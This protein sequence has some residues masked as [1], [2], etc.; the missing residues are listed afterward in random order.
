[1]KGITVLQFLFC[2]LSAIVYAGQEPMEK[3]EEL[4]QR[5]EMAC[6]KTL[7]TIFAQAQTS[8]GAKEDIITSEWLSRKEIKEIEH[9]MSDACIELSFDCNVKNVIPEKMQ[10]YLQIK[11]RNEVDKIF[12]NENV[13]IDH[14]KQFFYLSELLCDLSQGINCH[15]MMRDIKNESF[16]C[17]QNLRTQKKMQLQVT[18]EKRRALCECIVLGAL[19]R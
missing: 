7:D 10:N 16:P 17:L 6:R 15:S 8:V 18:K 13:S 3:Y 12:E 11:I 4:V 2:C 19:P 14:I 5:Q 1:M 9:N